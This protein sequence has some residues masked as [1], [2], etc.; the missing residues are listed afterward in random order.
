MKNIELLLSSTIIHALGKSY[1]NKDYLN[2][3]KLFIKQLPGV[4]GGDIAEHMNWI[5]NT[6]DYFR[7][8]FADELKSFYDHTAYNEEELRQNRALNRK[9]LEY[10]SKFNA[11]ATINSGGQ[12]KDNFARY[13][14]LAEQFDQNKNVFLDFLEYFESA[15]A[16]TVPVEKRYI[17]F[18]SDR[19]LSEYLIDNYKTQVNLRAGPNDEHGR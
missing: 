3:N 7:H 17:T 1:R 2:F 14:F 11:S 12:L 18:G 5:G 10:F 19:E 13:K 8:V 6:L 15:G 9:N 4:R 16:G